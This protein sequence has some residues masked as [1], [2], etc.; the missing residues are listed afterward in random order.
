MYFVFIH[1]KSTRIRLCSK[2]QGNVDKCQ[3]L[4]CIDYALVK[5][6]LSTIVN[7]ER[8]PLLNYFQKHDT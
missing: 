1:Y 7:R 3:I 8:G 4:Q 2:L 6:E 5:E